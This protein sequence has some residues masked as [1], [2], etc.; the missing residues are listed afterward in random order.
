M[1]IHNGSSHEPK[2]TPGILKKYFGE[3][4]L[5]PE[6]LTRPNA[7]LIFIKIVK[8]YLDGKISIDDLSYLATQLYYEIKRPNWFLFDRDFEKALSE[9]SEASWYNWKVK[10]EIRRLKSILKNFYKI[11]Q[12]LVISEV[13]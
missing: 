3:Y 13:V 5:S 1:K 9:A 11:N 10:S 4:L 6:K 2:T 7:R 8:D 12:N